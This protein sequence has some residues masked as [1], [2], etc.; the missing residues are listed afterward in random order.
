LSLPEP[1]FAVLLAAMTTDKQKMIDGKS[2]APLTHRKKRDMI[3]FLLPVLGEDESGALASGKDLPP[4]ATFPEGH[5]AIRGVLGI[6]CIL[7]TSLR[8]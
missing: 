8:R 4:R 2:D 3:F 6:H 5:M 7:Q 1:R